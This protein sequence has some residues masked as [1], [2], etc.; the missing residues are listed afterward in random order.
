MSL[1]S[2]ESLRILGYTDSDFQEDSN[3]NK[4]A[5]EVNLADPFTK[6]LLKLVFEKHVNYMGLTLE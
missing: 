5:Y 6:I 2:N 1:Y 3:S 4:I